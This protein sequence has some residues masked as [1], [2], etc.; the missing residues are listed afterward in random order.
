MNE[1]KRLFTQDLTRTGQFSR[2]TTDRKLE[3]EVDA[4]HLR[5][6]V[7]GRKQKVVV[8]DPAVGRVHRVGP[9]ELERTPTSLR[10]RDRAGAQHTINLS[11]LKSVA[12][13]AEQHLLRTFSDGLRAATA[14]R[15]P[16]VLQSS[17]PAIQG[18]LDRGWRERLERLGRG[19][20]GARIIE[21]PQLH[22]ELMLSALDDPSRARLQELERLLQDPKADTARLQPELRALR[23]ITPSNE[24]LA[25]LGRLLL[26][27][28]AELPHSARLQGALGDGTS[29]RASLLRGIWEV[30]CGEHSLPKVQGKLQLTALAAGQ[31]W[32]QGHQTPRVAQVDAAARMVARWPELSPQ[33]RDEWIT[34]LALHPAATNN[35]DLGEPAQALRVVSAVGADVLQRL[36]D[37]LQGDERSH[38][39]RMITS[40]VLAHPEGVGGLKEFLATRSAEVIGALGYSYQALFSEPL[41]CGDHHLTTTEVA[42]LVQHLR[43]PELAKLATAHSL[44]P[45]GLSQLFDARGVP[46]VIKLARRLDEDAFVATAKGADVEGSAPSSALPLPPPPETRAKVQPPPIEEVLERTRRLLA[47][48]LSD[49]EA[50][51]LHAI[52][53]RYL[54]PGVDGRPETPFYSLAELNRFWHAGPIESGRP[55]PTAPQL[56]ARW[57]LLTQRDRIVATFRAQ[58]ADSKRPEI[59][60]TFVD[61]ASGPAALTESL[62]AL[63]RGLTGLIG[64][65]GLGEHY[66]RRRAEVQDAPAQGHS[67]FTRPQAVVELLSSLATRD[68]DEALGRFDFGVVM[69]EEH[70]RALASEQG[71]FGA[72]HQL[73]TALEL[74]GSTID[75]WLQVDERGALTV[76]VQLPDGTDQGPRDCRLEFVKDRDGSLSLELGPVLSAEAP[77]AAQELAARIFANALRRSV[78]PLLAQSSGDPSS[79]RD[80]QRQTLLRAT[81]ELGRL[82][83]AELSRGPSPT[84]WEAITTLSQHLGYLLSAQGDPAEALR[85]LRGR[86]YADW[87]R[88]ELERLAGDPGM[89][90]PERGPPLLALALEA[91]SALPEAERAAHPTTESAVALPKELPTAQ[92][93]GL[94]PERWG[95]DV[96]LESQR[97]TLPLT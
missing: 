79:D 4:G 52:L 91:M 55:I 26:R 44:H 74:G 57:A 65:H 10:V 85:V 69:I 1:L 37:R 28:T 43:F 38:C 47:G 50:I 73:K 90:A 75:L 15:P 63:A 77:P 23:A 95:L 33:Q 51:E 19:E 32:L 31:A 89:D 48:R 84:P 16:V 12:T 27:V 29:G 56:G 92:V 72:A 46:G 30:M 3:V 64:R 70:G 36:H 60:A 24:D 41:P 7:D 61:A 62:E 14:G 17:R 83:I 87:L 42:S 49:Q 88:P 9:L 76:T 22:D 39:F 54:T 40:Y 21:L 20:V 8:E 35:S 71:R 97:L 34:W 96:Q 86:I 58:L 45:S 13:P 25:E 78:A 53:S 18:L 93:P 67:V 82:P 66:E 2:Q 11:A 80:R 59:L 6:T 94:A 5:V 68:R 81:I